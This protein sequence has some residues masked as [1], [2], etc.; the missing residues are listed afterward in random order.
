MISIGVSVPV[1]PRRR[2]ARFVA[3]FA[4]AAFSSLALA[5][6]EATGVVKERMDLMSSQK[7][8]M[9]LIGDM[10]KGKTPFDAAKAAA[11]ARNIQSTSAKIPELF[12]AGTAGH[13]SEAKEEI[14]QN[15]NDFTAKAKELD[16]AA[17]D[18]AA[19]L[20]SGAGDE[21]TA[22]FRQVSEACK[23]CHKSYRLEKQN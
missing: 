13:P 21:W 11:A 22:S 1:T 2:I 3:F 20:E 18:L 10:A 4:L 5:H 16:K 9:K 7:D 14:W 8:D 12:P 17:G 15:W 6:E 23:S 19:A